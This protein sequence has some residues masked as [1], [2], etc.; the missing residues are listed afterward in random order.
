MEE[1]PKEN[2][3]QPAAARRKISLKEKLAFTS[4]TITGMNSPGMLNQMLVPI[5]QIT[6]GMNPI[7]IGIVQLIM[8]VWDAFT[9]PF[10]AQW[11]DNTRSR[12][13]RRR[14]F[15]L[16]GSIL[17]ALFFPLIWFASDSWSENAKFIY[18]V[19]FC[20]VFLTSHTIFNIPYE[21]LGVELTTDSNERTRLYEFRSYLPPILGL[22]ISW[23]YAFVQSDF[24]GS[25]MEGM[26]I[27]AIGIGLIMLCTA[28]WAAILLKEAAPR[29]VAKTKKTPFLKNV[30]ETLSN[31]PFIAL[32]IIMVF[33][34]LTKSMFDQLNLYAKIYV[35]YDGDTKAGAMLSGWLSVVY[36]IVFM[37][38][39]RIGSV[40][41]QRYSKRAV[42]LAN[43][44][45][46]MLTGLVKYLCYNPNHPYLVLIIPLFAAPTGA[47]ASFMV[48]AMMADVA[49]YDRWKT[50]LRREG[51]FTGTASW[52]YKASFSLSGVLSG[53]LLVSIGFDVDLGGNQSEL[54]KQWLVL[55]LVLGSVIPGLITLGGLLIYNLSPAVMEKCRREVEAR[56]E[57]ED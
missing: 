6:L 4:G 45:L 10:V 18:L 12:W 32:M 43:A 19:V 11:S 25:T 22:G 37:F 44:G 30:A 3:Q 52:L 21:S 50:G 39:I 17:C 28:P 46:L 33:A 31:R 51:M 47:V 26:R 38:A 23:L 40:L 5:Y 36:F 49:F 34:Q 57:L 54:T 35:L 15:I 27:T 16:V 42:M 29:Q 2:P 53:I 9:D 56:E 14:P 48:N 8:R 24:F 20:L 55:G 1:A 7:L 13:G 41:A